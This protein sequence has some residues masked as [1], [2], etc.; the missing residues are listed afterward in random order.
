MLPVIA[1]LLTALTGPA[2]A[3]P[4]D[5]TAA[6]RARELCEAGSFTEPPARVSFLL[7]LEASGGEA[8]AGLSE[9]PGPQVL[10]AYETCLQ[11]RFGFSSRQA[12]CY[13]DFGGACETPRMWKQVDASLREEGAAEPEPAAAEDPAPSHDDAGP[14][15]VPNWIVG[16]AAEVPRDDGTWWSPGSEPQDAPDASSETR[17]AGPPIQASRWQPDDEPDTTPFGEPALWYFDDEVL[18]AWEDYRALMKDLAAQREVAQVRDE[19]REVE[20]VMKEEAR[21]RETLEALLEAAGTSPAQVAEREEQVT[22]M[23]QALGEQGAGTDDLD[24]G[25]PL[26]LDR[27]A[28]GAWSA[29]QDDYYAA[30]GGGLGEE[31]ECLRRKLLALAA[32]QKRASKLYGDAVD[33]AQACDAESWTLQLRLL[34]LA[35]ERSEQISQEATDCM[36]QEVLGASKTV[37]S[38]EAPLEQGGDPLEPLEGGTMGTVAEEL[39]AVIE[40]QGDPV[41]PF[42]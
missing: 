7:L 40:V 3:S 38:V 11:E 36:E 19:P 32:Y 34:R 26:A 14:P 24:T 12:R 42:E 28:W 15:E 17:P 31:A 18:Q 27:A 2:Q 22:C 6:D 39:Q 29:V 23:R 33:A 41:S 21:Q 10:A 4:D 5:A 1:L 16:R 25:A 37:V 8:L 35:V 13:R 9:A 30:V 20:R